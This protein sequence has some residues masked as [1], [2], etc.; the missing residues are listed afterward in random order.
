MEH[1]RRPAWLR[2]V[3]EQSRAAIAEGVPLEGICLYPVMNHPGW[4]NDRHTQC[5]MLDFTVE[6]GERPVYHPLA[7]E[8]RFQQTLFDSLWQHRQTVASTASAG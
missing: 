1:D 4:D 2:Y 6:N 5:G 3:C 8:L 7:A